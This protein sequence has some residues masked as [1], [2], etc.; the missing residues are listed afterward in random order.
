[1]RWYLIDRIIECVPGESIVGIKAFT[2]SEH[3]FADH[4]H[5]FPIVPGVLQI[6]MMATTGGKA[7]KLKDNDILPILGS[8]KKAKFLGQIRPGDQ[9]R[10]YVEI[11][12]L[13]KTYACAEARVEVDGKI[14]SK[15]SI[16]YAIL[17]ATVGDV[18]WV[19]PVMDEWRKSNKSNKQ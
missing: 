1:M 4:F 5:G 12:K 16:M 9:C 6:E 13:A 3:F 14:V 18:S 7:I 19:D 10:I 8:V 15:A 17:P 2:R 11:E